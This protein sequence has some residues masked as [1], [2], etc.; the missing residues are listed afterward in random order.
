MRAPFDTLQI[1]ATLLTLSGLNAEE[2]TG[3]VPPIRALLS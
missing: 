2:Y 1:A 3:D